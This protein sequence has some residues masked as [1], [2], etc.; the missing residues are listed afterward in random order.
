MAQRH[1]SVCLNEDIP[2]RGRNRIGRIHR[3]GA[4][5]LKPNG[6]RIRGNG[7]RIERHSDRHTPFQDGGA[8]GK[9]KDIVG[10]VLNRDAVAGP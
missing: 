1:R 3:K 4:A 6:R 5:R 9:G 8:L 2:P 10:E 7:I